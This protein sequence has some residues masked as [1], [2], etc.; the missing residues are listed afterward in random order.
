MPQHTN[1]HCNQKGPKKPLHKIE[2]ELGVADVV[3]QLHYA[4]IGL[5]L[6]RH[7][8]RPERL[9]DKGVGQVLDDV[10]DGVPEKTRAK[11]RKVVLD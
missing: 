1:A 9:D 3:G 6:V 7:G 2:G 10:A 4:T 5:F 8:V 11:A